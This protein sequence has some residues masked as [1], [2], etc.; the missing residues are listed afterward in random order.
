MK[1]SCVDTQKSPIGAICQICRMIS[2]S[3][4]YGQPL[5]EV[6]PLVDGLAF[7]YEYLDDSVSLD[8]VVLRDEDWGGPVAERMLWL[9]PGLDPLP[10]TV[11]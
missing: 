2:P 4:I 11:P 3:D 7:Q 10:D 9:S 5:E 1:P 8:R 6:L